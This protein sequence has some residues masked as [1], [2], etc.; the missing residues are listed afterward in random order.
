M[1]SETSRADD[2]I[3]NCQLADLGTR[4]QVSD[5]DIGTTLKLGLGEPGQR[6]MLLTHRRDALP[7]IEH[8]V[9][10]FDQSSFVRLFNG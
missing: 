4:L 7:V 9:P 2:H 5:T 1:T 10:L 6:S 8:S 3:N